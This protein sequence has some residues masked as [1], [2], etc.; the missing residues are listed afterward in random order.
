VPYSIGET[1]ISNDLD[2]IIGVSPS[3]ST[4]SLFRHPISRDLQSHRIGY[5]Y[6]MTSCGSQA[7]NT[8]GVCLASVHHMSITWACAPSFHVDYHWNITLKHLQHLWFSMC[9]LFG[10]LGLLCRWHLWWSNMISSSLTMF[11]TPN[12]A[13]FMLTE[14]THLPSRG[15]LTLSWPLECLGLTY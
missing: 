12:G 1:C 13:L 10:L 2:L 14:M 6:E 9:F 15:G 8:P 7:C 3:Q 11:R 5:H 4:T